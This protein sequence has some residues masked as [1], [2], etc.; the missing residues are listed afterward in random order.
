MEREKLSVMLESDVMRK[1]ERIA[2]ED[3]RSKSNVVEVLVAEALEAR[4]HA[5]T[6]S[7]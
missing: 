4:E 3:R 7:R 2:E 1:V 5:A 6:V